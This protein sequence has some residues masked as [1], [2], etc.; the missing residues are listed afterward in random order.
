MPSKWTSYHLPIA[1][2]MS[3]QHGAEKFRGPSTFT[4]LA[5]P[6]SQVRTGR[7]MKLFRRS[8]VCP[9]SPPTCVNVGSLGL[10]PRA[11]PFI[12]A[13]SPF[14]QWCPQGQDR[15]TM[16]DFCCGCCRTELRVSVLKDHCRRIN[17]VSLG[18]AGETSMVLAPRAVFCFSRRRM[19]RFQSS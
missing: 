7:N 10:G 4:L 18:H 19:C 9:R 6:S 8:L 16:H 11:L 3:Q 2:R 5:L 12:E 15:V 14:C 1:L 17:C 13:L